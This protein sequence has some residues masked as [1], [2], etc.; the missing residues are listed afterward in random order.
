MCKLP[1]F[2]VPRSV[3]E[4]GYFGCQVRSNIVTVHIRLYTHIIK[5]IQ[6]RRMGWASHVACMGRKRNGDRVLVGTTEGK[7]SLGRPRFRRKN[8]AIKVDI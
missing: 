7:W 4:T 3:S 2:I 1:L 6:L 8:S 5:V